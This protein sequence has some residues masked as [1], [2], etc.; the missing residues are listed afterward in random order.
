MIVFVELK[1]ALA[2][3]VALAKGKFF[4]E[5]GEK[6]FQSSFGYRNIN[7]GKVSKDFSYSYTILKRLVM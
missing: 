2:R 6:Y 5:K 7:D 4:S 1:I 3:L